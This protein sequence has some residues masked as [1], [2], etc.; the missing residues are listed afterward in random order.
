MASHHE[1]EL[2]MNGAPI[3]GILAEQFSRPGLFFANKELIA[4]A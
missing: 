1:E 3:I 2:S 4:G